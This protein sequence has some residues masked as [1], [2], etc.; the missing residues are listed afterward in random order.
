LEPLAELADVLRREVLGEAAGR[1]GAAAA[2]ALPT[3]RRTLA[4][5]QERL[6]FRAH[7]FLRQE[8][9]GYSPT[10]EDLA[11]AAT[12]AAAM[13]AA[14]CSDAAAPTRAPAPLYPPVAAALGALARL[15]GAVEAPT[16]GSLAQEAVA[17]ATTAVAAAASPLAAA[18]A[19]AGEPA[20]HVALSA[21]A[22]V[23]GQLL[24]LREQ[25]ASFDAE[26]VVMERALEFSAMRG[27]LR[28]ILSGDAPLFSLSAENGL[29]ALAARG[30]PR[31]VEARMDG[32]QELAAALKAA[33]EAFIL[34]ATKA[35][36]EPLLGFLAKATAAR[37]AGGAT[38]LR[39]QAFAAVARVTELVAA[40]KAAMGVTLAAA[41]AR[42]RAYLPDPATRH[43]LFK[44][45]KGNIVEAHA[46]M[47]ALLEA[48]YSAED[49]AAVGLTAPPELR[50][51]LDAHDEPAGDQL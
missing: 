5:V 42:A 47:A 20:A 11:A 41:A 48:E 36:V 44:P 43:A 19:A 40:T 6:A 46:Q 12:R 4:D 16:F 27:T 26:F 31:T 3:L 22:F 33:C 49:V 29:L 23:A 10:R 7:T 39:D 30:A 14:S 2:A 51:L 21:H 8:V 28:R 32:R 37:G 13:V 38:R 25:T 24:A 1:H 35:A 17:A 50:A 45:I 9:A 34:A 15:Y 18:A